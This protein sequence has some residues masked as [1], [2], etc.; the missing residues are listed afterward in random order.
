MEKLFQDHVTEL[1]ARGM[2]NGDHVR[3]AELADRAAEELYVGEIDAYMKRELN[4]KAQFDVLKKYGLLGI[5]VPKQY[6]GMGGDAIALSLLFERLGQVGMGVVTGLD[7]QTCLTEA[8]LTRWANEDQKKKYLVPEAKGE[9]FMSFCLTEPG[10]GSDPSSLQTTFEEKDGGFV[11]NGEKYLITNGSIANAFIVFCRNKEKGISAI[12]VD[13]DEHVEKEA[14][15]EE[16]LGLFTSDT[17]LLKFDNAFAPKENLLGNFGDG[18]K[19][20]YTGLL[21]G[22]L[23]IAAG[24]V[25]VAEDCL[26][27]AVSRSKERIQFGKEIGKHQ[28][29]QHRISVVEQQLGI[30]SGS[31][32]RAAY[33]KKRYDD[34]PQDLELRK[35]ADH[36]VTLAKVIATNAAG[37]AA[38]N[39][40]QLFGGSG[41]SIL[42][43][44]G[45]HYIDVRA[46]R[47][48]E[49][50]ND[51]LELKLASD[52]L[53][54][55]FEAYK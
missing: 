16:K 3:F 22:R 35:A 28:L 41:Y 23:G 34:D 53:G 46:S 31:V 21:T 40:I 20:A 11:I 36:N 47:I 12:I 9:R 8:I 43:A 49:G 29:V 25:G 2:I 39:A 55:G 18:L 48:Y 52:L 24:C 1:K 27:A 54:K 50:S 17:T 19:L 26:N 6:S 10:E 5:H 15:I 30:A 13:K 51:V 37:L 32:E 4:V 33:W 44:V 45:R 7:V 38:D 14:E 42:T